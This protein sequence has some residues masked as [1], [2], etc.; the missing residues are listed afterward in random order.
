[1]SRSRRL[2]GYVLQYWRGWALILLASLA[3]TAFG[4]LQAWPMKVLVDHVLGR[5]PMP[6]PL[7]MVFGPLPGS[8]S[9]H[10]LLVWVVLAGLAVFAVNSA[11]EVFLTMGWVRVGQRM[12]YDLQADLF[13]HLQR[14]SLL[15]H[16]RNPVGDSIGRITQDCWCLHTIVD[17]VLFK[18]K[19]ALISAAAMIGLMVQLDPGL[20]LL[21]LAVAPF[22]A[23]TSLLLGGTI[24]TAV[25]S[26]REVESR[27]EAHVQRTLSGLAVV[28]AF[29]RE[30]DERRRFEDLA[31]A[32]IATQRRAAWVGSLQAF[33]AGLAAALATIAIL[34]IGVGR[35]LAGRLT[36]GGIIVFLSYLGLLQ[37][38]LR[39][40]AGLYTSL[41]GA[42]VGAA[43][44]LEVLETDCEVRDRPGAIVLPTPRGH[45]QL[46]HVA[47]GYEPGRPVL[48]DVCLEVRPGEMLAL[49]GPT[50]AGKSTLAGLIPRFFDPWNGRVTLDGHD[51]RDVQ[52]RSLRAHV[53][54]VLQES[55]LFPLTVAENIAYGRP[56]ACFDQ[57][58]AAA[59]AA[60]AH[61]FIEQLTEGYQTRLGE[62]GATLSGGERQRLA[63][64]RA[65]LVDAPVLVLDEPTSALDTETE[66][67][68]LEALRRLRAGRTTLIITH[69][70]TVAA[71]ADRV[72]LV[73]DGRIHESEEPGCEP[74]W[75][76]LDTCPEACEA[77]S[78][79]P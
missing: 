70:A 72:V 73:Q 44:V 35:V 26:R 29:G 51:L 75:S 27:I 5:A 54:L 4:L 40:L 60:C 12:V 24:R 67:R 2:L 31:G 16:V 42:A 59:R 79:A 43:R 39:A 19:L 76:V 11:L 9:P 78:L 37:S 55:F 71:Q 38:Q 15:F 74:P 25:R 58:E 13:G 50:G 17:D 64:A 57:V 49:I 23:G 65:L 56:G 10:G 33:W 48:H 20:T 69:R 32:A 61:D 63:I 30:D 14:R 21:A 45:L 6:Q 34:W 7:A 68:L 22:L 28:Q 8:G 18:P 62:R 41:Q 46:E 77:R 36:V 47:F 53:A 3:G 66:F 52:L 1:M